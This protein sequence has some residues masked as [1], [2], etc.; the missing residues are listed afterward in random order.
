M[1]RKHLILK[2]YHKK[3]FC[4]SEYTMKNMVL[5]AVGM[6]CAC[7]IA[8]M[9]RHSIFASAADILKQITDY[10]SQKGLAKSEVTLYSFTANCKFALLLFFFS[11]TNAWWLYSRCFVFYIGF[12]QGVLLSCCLFLKG[13]SG[14]FFYLGLLVPHAFVL[15][16]AYLFLLQR[17]EGWHH[18]FLWGEKGTSSRS[19]NSFSKKKKQMVLQI[20][21]LFF[22]IMILLLLGAFLEGYLNV[23]LLRLFHS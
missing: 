15:A 22:G 18:G 14:I 10:L 13:F 7:L 2:G 19:D 23:P 16:P 3:H 6:A 11:F 12:L 20:L 5:C 17:L 1:P 21:P 4:L 8:N 9:T